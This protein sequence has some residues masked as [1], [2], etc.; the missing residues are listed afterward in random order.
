LY[1]QGEEFIGVGVDK[2]LLKLVWGWNG[3]TDNKILVP[4]ASVADGEWHNLVLSFSTSNIT[5][6]VDRILE[7]SESGSDHSDSQPLTT[8]GIFYLGKYHYFYDKIKCRDS[9]LN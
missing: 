4:A 3:P 7:H 1:Q 6:W 9:T 2:G 5:L 8:D